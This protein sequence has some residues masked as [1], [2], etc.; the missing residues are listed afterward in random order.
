MLCLVLPIPDGIPSQMASQRRSCSTQLILV[1]PIP[2]GIPDG[3]GGGMTVLET[4]G[5]RP[6]RM[7]V[8]PDVMGTATH[9]A[10]ASSDSCETCVTDGGDNEIDFRR[11]IS[12]KQTKYRCFVFLR[13][14][15]D[16]SRDGSGIRGQLQRDSEMS[17]VELV[18]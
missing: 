14:R 11:N 8:G 9:A 1:L 12:P 17:V 10:V 15:K 3:K 13:P 7:A 6:H 2:D 16:A 4:D 5:T 18:E